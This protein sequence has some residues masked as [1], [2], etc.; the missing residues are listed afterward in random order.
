ML[1][2]NSQPILYRDSFLTNGG[3][4]GIE[5]LQLYNALL[6]S[7]KRLNGVYKTFN[8][9]ERENEYQNFKVWS[10]SHCFNDHLICMVLCCRVYQKGT[11]AM[12]FLWL[13]IVHAYSQYRRTPLISTS[14]F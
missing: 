10:G 3:G 4:G 14:H 13:C 9:W 2:I 1:S 12:E 8:V 11:A 7:I 6:L 5:T